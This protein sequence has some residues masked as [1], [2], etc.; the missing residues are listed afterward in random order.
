MIS[1]TKLA[2]AISLCLA[3]ALLLSGCGK[4]PGGD[5]AGART[6][7][8]SMGKL[9]N[10]LDPALA[11]DTPS[12]YMAGAFYDTPL[13]YSY[14]ERPYKLEPSMLAKMPEASEDLTAYTCTLREGLYFQDAA[15][16]KGMPK[17]ARRVTAKDLEFSILRL[18]DARL[19]S[20]GYWLLRGRVKGAE[21]FR[22]ATAKAAPG[23]LSVYDKGCEGVKALDERTFVIK[24]NAPDPRLPYMLA[25]PYCAAVSRRAVEFYGAS[26]A[27]HPAGSGPFMLE[28]WTKDYAI[29]FVRNPEYRQELF[30]EASGAQDRSR[31]L[32]LLDKVVCYL[33]KQPIA[34]W[35]M[36]L[37]G[38]LD[39]CALDGENFEAVVGADL[40]LVDAL[41][42]RR[43]TL[44]QAPE[45][46]TNYIGFNMGDPLLGSN[47]S[48]R[49]AISLAFDKG[50]RFKQSNGRLA[51]AYGPVP[52]GTPGC[53]E[54]F[55]GPFGEM[56]LERAKAL[57][58][59]AGFPDGVDPKT[60]KALEISFDQAGSDSFYRQTA[61]LMATDM[62]RIG[63]N[64]K[65]NF[66]NRPRFL[67]KLAQGQVQLFRFS[68]TGD[69]PDAEN[70]LQLFYGPNAGTCNRALYKDAEFDA[71]YKEIAAMRDS[72]ERTAKYE[73]MSKR[74]M[75]TC[76]W[77]FES[78]PMSFMLTHEWLENYQPHD[79]GFNRW[80]YLSVDPALREKAK[81]A[82]KPLSMD[83]LRK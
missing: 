54:G 10:T 26:F 7:R 21:A 16:F 20:G 49:Q 11:S 78:S 34:S 37:Q 24:L 57:M 3:A 32:P 19:K 13:Q 39:Y 28:S 69:Y 45:F 67:Q 5:E 79:F 30:P 77:I 4:A 31:A 1:G 36:F 46:Q 70:F 80:K 43:M 8:I 83:E 12:Q 35:L 62:R 48:L 74:L 56:D 38:D 6:L 44:W 55:K 41:A 66:N 71:L 51:P 64:L 17:E 73:A 40:K 15:C 72:P 63:I 23:D 53:V 47:Q 33:V 29:S 76:P 2:T 9:I 65:P 61:E 81:A 58:A 59:K 52:P 82:F 27:D 18:A 75:E 68:W 14:K 42:K 50:M 60:G 25:M 22:E